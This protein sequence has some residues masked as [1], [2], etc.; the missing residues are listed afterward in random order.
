MRGAARSSTILYGPPIDRDRIRGDVP[1]DRPGEEAS[2][3]IRTN[4]MLK[5]FME[6]GEAQVS[7]ITNQ[8]L[9]NEKF[10][11]AVQNIVSKTLSARGTLDKSL[12]SALATMNLPSTGDVEGL[13]SRL[14]DLD[15]TLTDLDA[16]L[17][18][19]EKKL[20]GGVEAGPAASKTRAGPRTRKA[21]SS[22]KAG[23][24]GDR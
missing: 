8:L 19:L 20:T 17:E 3:D 13:K 9:A 5:R 15:R 14:D 6:V 4:P 7:R 16:R 23:E 24:S 11:Q 21:P 12:R 1:P 22:K 18:R 10:L 2:V